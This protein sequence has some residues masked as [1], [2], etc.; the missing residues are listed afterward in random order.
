[1]TPLTILILGLVLHRAQRDEQP[2]LDAGDRRVAPAVLLPL[3]MPT[4]I[5][6]GEAATWEVV[7]SMAI[8]V[9]PPPP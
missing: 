6:L 5:A 2:G 8:S 3:V 1:M 7:A 4:R 9:A